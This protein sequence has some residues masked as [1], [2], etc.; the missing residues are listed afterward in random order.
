MEASAGGSISRLWACL[1]RGAAVCWYNFTHTSCAWGGAGG[2]AVTDGKR[3]PYYARLT[4]G[5][6]EDTKQAEQYSLHAVTGYHL[7]SYVHTVSGLPAPSIS[8][9]ATVCLVPCSKTL[10]MPTQFGQCFINLLWHMHDHCSQVDWVQPDPLKA[11]SPPSQCPS[12]VSPTVHFQWWD[13]DGCA[14]KVMC[15][16]CYTF[17]NEQ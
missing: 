14:R 9:H 6:E 13:A 1:A 8:E 3:V 4:L 2:W 7:S 15:Q 10:G 11:R 12:A 17:S 5:L 16:V